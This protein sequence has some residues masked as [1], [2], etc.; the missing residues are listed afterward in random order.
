MLHSDGTV[1]VT[2]S[3]LTRMSRPPPSP[4][5]LFALGRR[6]QERDPARRQSELDAVIGAF[7]ALQ[8]AV[9]W[10]EERH[11]EFENMIENLRMRMPRVA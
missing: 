2:A 10:T 9:V 4:G 6:R 11:D 7:G 1:E 3:G 5:Q 8:R